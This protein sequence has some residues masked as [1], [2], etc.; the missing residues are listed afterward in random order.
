MSPQLLRDK[1]NVKD[2]LLW[3]SSP[4]TFDSSKPP[5]QCLMFVEV[6]NERTCFEPLTRVPKPNAS[7]LPL[8]I[9]P[10]FTVS[11]TLFSLYTGNPELFAIITRNC[12]GRASTRVMLEYK[13]SGPPPIELPFLLLPSPPSCQEI[14][15]IICSEYHHNLQWVSSSS[16]VSIII[17]II[18]YPHLHL[19]SWSSSNI[20]VVI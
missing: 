11:P 3:L 1:L 2:S 5:S 12:S 20:M 19:P 9:P 6:K 18:Y 13:R 15:I 4:Y 7:I 16:S 14:I 10:G 8:M 17:I